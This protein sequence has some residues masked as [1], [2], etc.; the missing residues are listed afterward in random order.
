MYVQRHPTSV[1]SRDPHIHYY[2]AAQYMYLPVKNHSTCNL[3]AVDRH[4]HMYTQIRTHRPSIQP[5]SYYIPTPTLGIYPR[6]QNLPPPH[7]EYLFLPLPPRNPRRED[8]HAPPSPCNHPR[9]SAALKATRKADF[10]D[11]PGSSITSD[12][13]LRPDHL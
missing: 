2:R 5:S 3:G 12:H 4:A 9:T 11:F 13:S 7:P 8:H 1:E 6:T 10:P